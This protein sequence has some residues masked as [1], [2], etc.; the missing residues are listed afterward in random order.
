MKT[1]IAALIFGVTIGTSLVLG[2]GAAL[3]DKP[4]PVN[5]HRHYIMVN[6]AKVYIGP[7]F[8]DIDALAQGFAAFHH[9][10]HLTDPGLIDVL[11]EPCAD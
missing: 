5:A 10:V 4:T 11:S 7:N 3:A 1:R 9:H 6:G 2:S 8:C